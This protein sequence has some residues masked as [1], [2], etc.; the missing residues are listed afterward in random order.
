M[1]QAAES[2]LLDEPGLIDAYAHYFPTDNKPPAPGDVALCGHVFK[3]WPGIAPS[4]PDEI[5]ECCPVCLD[6]LDGIL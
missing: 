3:A 6:K 1:S 2:H 4:Q 5:G